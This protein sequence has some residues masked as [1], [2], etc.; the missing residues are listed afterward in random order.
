MN[1]ITSS[2]CLAPQVKPVS[3]VMSLLEASY[4]SEPIKRDCN[5]Q[6]MRKSCSAELNRDSGNPNTV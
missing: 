2:T 4:K 1:L 5:C 6:L 3:I